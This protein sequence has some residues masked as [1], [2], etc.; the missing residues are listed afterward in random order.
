MEYRDNMTPEELAQ[1][2]GEVNALDAAL[3][4]AD[5]HYK[6]AQD[7]HLINAVLSQIKCD[8]DSEDMTAIEELVKHLPKNLLQG[9]LSEFEDP[10]DYVGMGWI[11]SRGRA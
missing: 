7:Q 9:Y 3:S 10:S 11:D 1:F 4:A 6:K 2:M 5:E 8:V